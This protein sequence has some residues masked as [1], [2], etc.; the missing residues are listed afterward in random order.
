MK[1]FDPEELGRFAG[2]DGAPVYVSIEGKVY[3]VSGS[4]LWETGTHMARHTAGQ[5]LDDEIGAA[6]HGLEVLERVPQ[7]GILKKAPQRTGEITRP[8]LLDRYPFLKRHPHPMTVHFPIALLTAAFAFEALF[9]LT[10]CPAFR[11]TSL[12]CLALGFISVPFAMATG[13]LSWQL[14]YLGRP[15]RQVRIKITLSFIMAAVALLT[16]W[17]MW[18]ATARPQAGDF[19]LSSVLVIAALVLIVGYFGGQLTFPVEKARGGA[20]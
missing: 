17:R 16:L 15:M 13:Y 8:G 10:G 9:A 2:K 20:E 6:P 4:E 5:A 11:T 18:P 14:N 12:H 1:E 7:I 19:Y 3:D